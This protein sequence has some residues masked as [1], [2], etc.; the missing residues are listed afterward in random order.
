MTYVENAFGV[1]AHAKHE[2]KPHMARAA[3]SWQMLISRQQTVSLLALLLAAAFQNVCPFCY[4]NSHY[5]II[6]FVY[7]C[8]F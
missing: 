5:T 8:I 4:I 7:Y 3:D 2:E 1:F 6:H